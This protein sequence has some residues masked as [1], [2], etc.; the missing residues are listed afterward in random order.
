MTR[1]LAAFLIFAAAL[2]V[3]K[4]D[5]ICLKDGRFVEGKKMSRTDGGIKI[6]FDNGEVFV[7]EAMIGD[8]MIEGEAL[9]EPKTDE[10]R[11]QAEKGMVRFEGKWMSPKT[12]EDQLKKRLDKRLKDLE[13]FKA[14]SEWRNR[15][16]EK[17]KNF[18]FEYTIPPDVFENYRDLMEAYFAQFM[19]DWKLTPPKGLGRLKVCL[20][21]DYGEMIQTGGAGGGVLGYFRFVAPMELNFFHDRLDTAFTE[22]VMFHETNHYLQKLIDMDFS[23]PHFPGESLAEYY[24]ASKWDPVKKKLT[25]GLILEGRLVEVQ[26]DIAGGTMMD[27]KKLISTDRMYEHYNWGWALV[28]FL[29]NDKR[30]TAKFQ[31][32]I[33]SLPSAKDIKRELN[34]MN[35]KDVEQTEVAAAF[36]RYLDI[37]DDAALKELEKEW[38]AYIK[39]KLTLV[40]TRGKEEAAKSAAQSGRPLKAKRLYKE[41]ITAGTANPMTYNKYAQLLNWD[42]KN[43]EAHEMW[44]RAIALDPLTGDYYWNMGLS[45]AGNRK[46]N[47]DEKDKQEGERLKK[48]AKEIEP[49]GSF[50]QWDLVEITSQPGDG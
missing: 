49:G 15:Y 28:H 20:Y 2:P 3:A 37:K 38:H 21:S 18:E 47:K 31:K 30:Y 1:L 5:F 7:P 50:S 9:A 4:A 36:M 12:R 46:T 40:T 16:T 6:A 22:E 29:M 32:F 43:T 17:S 41:A 44:K 8:V 33:V 14:H 10:E 27:L 42:G 26:D 25:T 24:G 34:G 23:M 45:M 35:L 48:L 19:R 39:E 13:T 11:A